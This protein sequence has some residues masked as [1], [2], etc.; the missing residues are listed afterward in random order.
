MLEQGQGLADDVADG[1]SADIA[2]GIGEDIQGAQSPLAEKGEQDAFAVADL[3]VEDTAASAG[4]AW[5]ATSL[6]A[7]AF[8][9]GGL[10][11]SQTAG[12]VMQL[13][14]G[15]PGQRRVG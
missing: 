1:G 12:E 8:G 13:A 5:A 11:R 6:V 14:L 7:E 3:L 9:L 15:E 10:P 2:E 4:L